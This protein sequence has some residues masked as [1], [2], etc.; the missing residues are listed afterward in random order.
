MKTRLGVNSI[1]IVTIL[2]L[3]MALF[4]NGV[5]GQPKHDKATLPTDRVTY[6]LE[7]VIESVDQSIKYTAP[8]S[9]VDAELAIE[10]LNLVNHKLVESLKY[11][12]PEILVDHSNLNLENLN[13]Q[14]MAS[15]KY[16]AP[17]Y[18]EE[19][20]EPAATAIM[21]QHKR[22]SS[23]VKVEVYSCQNQ[24]LINAGYLKSDRT[25]AWEKVKRAFESKNTQKEYANG[26]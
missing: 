17:E 2:T 10:E 18:T 1:K 13:E 8:D 5:N 7:N 26:F 19:I 9:E 25:P 4:N 15:L 22:Y 14:T 12:A 3:V 23:P 24:W 6:T 20:N 16:Q 21:N 11:A